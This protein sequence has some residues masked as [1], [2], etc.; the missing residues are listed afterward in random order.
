MLSSTITVTT[1]TGLVKA[2]ANPS[3][4]TSPRRVPTDPD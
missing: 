1:E 4:A 2:T 3:A